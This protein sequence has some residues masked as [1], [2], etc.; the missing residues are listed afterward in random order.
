MRQ[1]VISIAAIALLMAPASAA[2][3]WKVDT[4]KSKLGFTVSW[5]GQPFNGAFRSWKSD[6]DFDP[7]DLAHSH[8]EIT[9][10]LGSET[11]GDAETDGGIKSADGFAVSQFPNAVFRTTGFTHKSGNDYVAAGTLSIKGVSRNIALP[12]TLTLSGNSAHVVGHAQ[13]M[14]TDFNVGTGEWAKPDPVAH[15]VTV[16]VD[17]TATKS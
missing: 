10:D 8:A 7:A 11:S 14:R 9:I 2:Q 16:N 6:I 13:V 15:A 12:F 17:L 1:I 4:A 3:R 5:G